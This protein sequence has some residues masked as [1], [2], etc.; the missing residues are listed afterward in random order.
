MKFRIINIPVFLVLMTRT[1]AAVAETNAV[2]SS[3][4]QSLWWRDAMLQTNISVMNLYDADGKFTG[5]I[6]ARDGR[7]SA[8]D[9]NNVFIIG[10]ILDKGATCTFL[11]ASNQYAGKA[12]STGSHVQFYDENGAFSGKAVRSGRI[13]RFYDDRGRYTGKAVKDSSGN[14]RFYDE[15][16]VPKGK[17]ER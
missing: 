12:V 6:T 3:G 1:I 17:A 4:I 2:A 13:T 10:A 14:I 15:R 5:K 16:G 9:T 8:Q 11:N 7:I